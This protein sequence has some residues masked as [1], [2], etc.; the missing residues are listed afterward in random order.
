MTAFT[1]NLPRRYD[2]NMY[3]PAERAITDAMY[4]VEHAGCHLL[5]TDAIILLEQAR[6]KVSDY[7]DFQSI[8]V[9]SRNE[10]LIKDT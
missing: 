2:I 6:N 10:T 4:A 7:V 1:R 8:D 3:T 9:K 5:L